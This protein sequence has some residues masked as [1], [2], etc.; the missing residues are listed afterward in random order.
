QTERLVGELN[1]FFGLVQRMQAVDTQGVV[2]LAHP[3]DVMQ[4]VAL[5][6]ANDTATEQVDRQANQ[7]SAPLVQDGLYLVPRVVE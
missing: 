4:E 3:T 5:R 6:L 1:A 7:R 2:P